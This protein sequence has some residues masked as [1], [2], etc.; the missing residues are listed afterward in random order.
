MRILTEFLYPFEDR[1]TILACA[2]R[3][4]Q[5][6]KVDSVTPEAA[7]VAM[8]RLIKWDWIRLQAGKAGLSTRHGERI[9]PG[10]LAD[11]DEDVVLEKLKEFDEELRTREE[12]MTSR[13]SVGATGRISLFRLQH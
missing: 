11:V 2:K 6:V 9:L 3:L 4:T 13:R 1:S 7:R 5:R 8:A 12:V 10:K